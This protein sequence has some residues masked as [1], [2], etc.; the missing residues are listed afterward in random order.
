MPTRR[1]ISTSKSRNIAGSVDIITIGGP[2]SNKASFFSNLNRTHNH[3]ERKN[4]DWN[5]YF[6]LRGTRR[7]YEYAFMVPST[8]LGLLG[9]GYY[10]TR[11][12]FDP[13]MLIFGVDQVLVYGIGTIASALLGL[14]LGAVVGNVIFRSVHSNARPLLDKVRGKRNENGTAGFFHMY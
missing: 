12:D 6:A 3:V 4:M 2:Y 9:G 1:F 5:S 13:T 14:S 7:L 8:V 10:F 11:Q